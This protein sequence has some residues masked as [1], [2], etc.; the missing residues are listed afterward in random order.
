MTA[1]NTSE[2]VAQASMGTPQLQQDTYDSTFG[3][4]AC[5]KQQRLQLYT[6][7]G[8]SPRHAQRKA[9]HCGSVRIGAQ[10]VSWNATSPGLPDLVDLLLGHNSGRSPRQ[11]GAALQPGDPAP[12]C[13]GSSAAAP[14]AVL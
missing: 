14:L 7:L 2:Q 11:L 12:A 13:A 5:R 9:L 3:I 8:L 1:G 4:A 10:E 6:V